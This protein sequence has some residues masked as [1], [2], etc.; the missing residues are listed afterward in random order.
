MERLLDRCFPDTRYVIDVTRQSRTLKRTL[1]IVAM[2]QAEQLQINFRDTNGVSDAVDNQLLVFD[3]AV[4]R[5]R[6]DTELFSDRFHSEVFQTILAV[7]VRS[8]ATNMLFGAH[9]GRAPDTDD[10]LSNRSA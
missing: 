7:R 9:H 1:T 8:V 5:A 3:P 2:R 6:R 10:A 4:N